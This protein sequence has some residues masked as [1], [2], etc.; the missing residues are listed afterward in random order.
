M[1]GEG[2]RVGLDAEGASRAGVER[3]YE[4]IGAGGGAGGGHGASMAPNAARERVEP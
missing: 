4:G 1:I 3:Q 2:S